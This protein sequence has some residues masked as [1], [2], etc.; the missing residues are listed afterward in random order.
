MSLFVPYENQIT[1]INSIIEST[2]KLL[3]L[4]EKNAPLTETINITIMQIF[5]FLDKILDLV[6]H[7]LISESNSNFFKEELNNAFK[8]VLES[9]DN[10]AEDQVAFFE[11]WKEFII[12][13]QEFNRTVEKL[14]EV[15][16]TVY[17]SMN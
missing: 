14:K 13:W 7:L 8:I 2:N 16:N 17:L 9:W 12:W 4:I 3:P 15:D 5:R 10:F 1:L 11:A 6:P